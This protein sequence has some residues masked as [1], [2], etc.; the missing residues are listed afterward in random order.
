MANPGENH[1]EITQND[2]SSKQ[3]SLL[4][5][6]SSPPPS[7]NPLPALLSHSTVAMPPYL[8][9]RLGTPKYG[10]TTT[11]HR[12]LAKSDVTIERT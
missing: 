9:V 2:L 5:S 3:E 8:I 12:Q 10:P 1:T 7:A 4:F 11:K 6:F